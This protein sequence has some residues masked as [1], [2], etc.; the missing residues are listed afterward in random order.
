MRY[1]KH[2]ISN[3]KKQ[4]PQ[5]Y[6]LIKT[7]AEPENYLIVKNM[8]KKISSIVKK[9]YFFITLFIFIL[10]FFALPDDWTPHRI[11]YYIF[12]FIPVIV[13]SI[14]QRFKTIKEQPAFWLLLLVFL[15][16]TAVSASWSAETGLVDA[17][18]MFRYFLLVASFLL[19]ITYAH[20]NADTEILLRYLVLCIGGIALINILVYY[21]NNP[22]PNARVPAL[23]RYGEVATL[24]ANM[25]GLFAAAG[26]AHLLQPATRSRL[27]PFSFWSLIAAT[28][29]LLTFL[30][31]AQTRGA[32]VALTLSFGF[33]LM[34]YRHWKILIFMGTA[35]ILLIV[36]VELTELKIGLFER[37]IGSRPLIWLDAWHHVME[38]PFFG[39]GMTSSFTLDCGEKIFVHPHNVILYVLLQTGF[40]GL[41][42]WLSLT[43]YTVHAAYKIGKNCQDWTLLT[44][45]LFGILTMMFTSR[46]FLSSPNTTWLLYWLPIGLIMTKSLEIKK[47]FSNDW[48]Q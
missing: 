16:Y 28:G 5:L 8:A 20:E 4:S 44:I 35:V 10:G 1:N 30:V 9:N 21:Q 40:I 25:Y 7:F 48:E 36:S 24:G 43:A 22:F 23:S 12:G 45:I 32:I 34:I 15:S 29:I 14:R 41:F 2:W 39:H 38:R 6:I 33:L 42:L 46:D 37:G 19:F 18:D 27:H 13:V 3:N 17:Y 47:N 11:F 31:L 26:L